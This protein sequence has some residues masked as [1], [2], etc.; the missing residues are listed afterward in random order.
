MSKSVM[1]KDQQNGRSSLD[2]TS[3]IYIDPAATKQEGLSM[4]PKGDEVIT[5]LSG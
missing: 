4:Y 1:M 3:N 5:S 2:A